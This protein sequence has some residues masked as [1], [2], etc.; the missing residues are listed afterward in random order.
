MYAA[1]F[2]LATATLMAVGATVGALLAVVAIVVSVIRSAFTMGL[3]DASVTGAAILIR[4]IP[5]T[6]FLGALAFGGIESCRSIW[7]SLT[8]TLS[9]QLGKE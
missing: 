7:K 2:V 4:I 8:K 1:F 6:I 5:I 9:Q 3:Y